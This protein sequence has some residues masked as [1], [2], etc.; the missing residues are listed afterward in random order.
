[1]KVLRIGLCFLFAFSVLALG[2]VDV[3]SQSILEIGAS[4]LFF[5][6]ALLIYQKGDTKIEWSPLN[7]PLLGFLAIGLIQLLFHGTAYPFHTRTELLKL[8]AYFLIFFLVA[9]AF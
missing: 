1:M 8:A 3:W 9:Q 4:A 6:W 7:W 2:A 5:F